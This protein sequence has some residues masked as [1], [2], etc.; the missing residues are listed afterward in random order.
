MMTDNFISI[1]LIDVLLPILNSVSFIGKILPPTYLFDQIK[2][3]PTLKANS[4]GLF[5]STKLLKYT[6]SEGN[7]IG[8]ILIIK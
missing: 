5:Y 2:I 7:S 8:N 4:P 6:A 3:L 1:L